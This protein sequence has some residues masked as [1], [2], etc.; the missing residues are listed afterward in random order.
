MHLRARLI[1]L[2]LILLS[3]AC[4]RGPPEDIAECE[5]AACQ[6]AWLERALDQGPDAALAGLERVEDPIA[7]IALIS[8]L[9]EANP[10]KTGQLCGR[11]P[12]GASRDRCEHINARPH[13]WNAAMSTPSE[14]PRTREGTG[15]ATSLLPTP[16]RESSR[17]NG[18]QSGPGPC[19]QRA[20]LNACL[21]ARA[22]REAR[23]GNVPKAALACAGM[24]DEKWRT[25]CMFV[26]AEAL[27]LERGAQSYGE[28]VELCAAAGGFA[29]NC[30]S[31]TLIEL[32]DQAPDAADTRA[33]AWASVVASAQTIRQV[34]APRD[35]ALGE[36]YETRFW[37]EVTRLAYG[38]TPT[39]T[40]APLD[41]LPPQAAPYV[42]A[43]AAGALVRQTPPAAGPTLES[44]VNQLEAALAIRAPSA[45][46]RRRGHWFGAE[47]DLWPE[48][49]AGDEAVPAILHLGTSR[50]TYAEDLRS[51][52]AIC[53]VEAAARA[54]V[55]RFLARDS[56]GTAAWDAVVAQ[57]A[58]W[59]D[60]RV[61]WT[62]ERLTKRFPTS[63]TE[64]PDER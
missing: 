6:V 19:T 31:H 12:R 8:A 22:V 37:A 35:P 52:L 46:D 15:P 23:K 1:G 5:D 43:A 9:T 33:P 3:L 32:A 47:L 45:P 36:L 24:P 57:G 17:Y 54:A 41:H 28:A 53:V 42:R 20:D 29:A 11:M 30:M 2:S 18:V 34:W 7:R 51:D 16:P 50:R 59:P 14:L 60:P 44:L 26:S 40:G 10:G 27:V 63:A 62:T 56:A 21:Q 64:Q 4:R 48:D 13:L 58:S 49:Q 39:V 25:E 55:E 38:Q 61:Q